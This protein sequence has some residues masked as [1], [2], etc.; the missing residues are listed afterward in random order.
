[1]EDFAV[2]VWNDIKRIIA[3]RLAPTQVVDVEFE[4]DVDHDG[5]EIVRIGIVFE[6]NC[7]R[8]KAE[9]VVG[10]TGLVR[11]ALLDSHNYR[12]PI[13]TFMTSQERNSDVV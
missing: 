4:E 10:L 3:E 12:F 13:L 6:E 5:D 2:D 1:M 11:K 8:P 9:K 7:E